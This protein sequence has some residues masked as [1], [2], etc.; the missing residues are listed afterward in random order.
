MLATDVMPQF[1]LKLFVIKLANNM[2]IFN[3]VTIQLVVVIANDIPGC[4]SSWQTACIE[5]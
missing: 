4:K 3:K 1:Y 2:P 5:G